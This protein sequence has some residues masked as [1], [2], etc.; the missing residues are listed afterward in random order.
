MIPVKRVFAYAL[1]SISAVAL[2]AC[3]GHE[4][5]K[6]GTVVTT[7]AESSIVH[8]DNIK[9]T[10]PADLSNTGCL[11]RQGGIVLL[12]S[13]DCKDGRVLFGDDQLWGY[14]GGPAHHTVPEDDPSYGKA[15]DE[16]QGT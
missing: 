7:K 12:G 14:A 9:E 6:D 11:N 13:W 2:S 16:C 5:H 15:Y 4:G 3:G 8:C 1:T 10:I